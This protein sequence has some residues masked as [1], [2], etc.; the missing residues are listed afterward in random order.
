MRKDDAEAEIACVVGAVLTWIVGWSLLNVGGFGCRRLTSD[1]DGSLLNVAGSGFGCRRL[2]SDLDGSLLNVAGSGFWC[3]RLTSDL[4]CRL[5]KRAC[6]AFTFRCCEES[7]PGEGLFAVVSSRMLLSLLLPTSRDSL[8][9]SEG[10]WWWW[11]WW[12]CGCSSKTRS[13]Q[14]RVGDD[15][16]PPPPPPP[17]H[18]A[19]RDKEAFRGLYPRTF[20]SVFLFLW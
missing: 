19:A 12:W 10:V 4:A 2:T 17:P 16:P 8:P 5:F 20:T 6:C 1:L 7:G 11:W 13:V 9:T 15:A 3:R 18:A 14:S